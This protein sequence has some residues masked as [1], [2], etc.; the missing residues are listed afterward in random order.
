MHSV[1]RT[2]KAGSPL[3]KGIHSKSAYSNV[4]TLLLPS[5]AIT[6]H[7]HTHKAAVASLSTATRCSGASIVTIPAQR[8]LL[9]TNSKA[10]KQRFYSTSQSTSITPGSS[11]TT[12]EV[13]QELESLLAKNDYEGFQKA[14]LTA[15]ANI[16][17]DMYHFLL[18]TLAEHP[19][20]FSTLSSL[21]SSTAST[22][23]TP[24]SA[25]SHG[26]VPSDPINS[27]INILTDMSHEANMG[28][29]ALQPDRETILLLLGVA[30]SKSSLSP[31][32]LEQGGEYGAWESIRVLV[33]AIR[34]GRLPAVMSSDQWELPDLNFELD[35][36]LWKAMFECVHSSAAAITA[37]GSGLKGGLLQRELDTMTFLM[38]D[39]LIKSQDVAMD[40]QLWR[41]VVEAFGN[42]RS[43]SRLTNILPKLP[44]MD[45]ESSELYST[46]SEALANS[47]LINQAMNIMSSLSATLDALPSISPFIALARQHAKIGDYEAI[48]HDLKVWGVKGASSPMND[49]NL[50]NLHRSMLVASSTALDRLVN[51]ASRS[52]KDRQMNTLPPDV[53]PG[54]VTPPQ[55]S[56][57]QYSEAT[58]LWMRSQ[59]SMNAIP[60]GEQTPEDYDVSMRIMTRLNLL[61]PNEWRLK[62]AEKLITD[63]KQQGLKPLQ[64]TYYTLMETIARTR[65]YGVSREGGEVAERVIKVFKDMTTQEGYTAQSAKDFRPL[66]EA[67]FGIY[68]YSPFSA[69]QWVYSNQLYPASMSALKKVEGMM[70]DA[71]APEADWSSDNSNG[72]SQFHDSI[73]IASVLGG[74]GHGDKVEELLK[75]WESLPLEGIERDTLLYQTFIGASYGQEK[76]ARYVLRTARYDMLKEQPA[77]RMTPEIFAG[78]LNCCVRVQD[79]ISARALIAQYSSSGDIQKTAEWYV[80]MVRTCLMIN[81]MEEE[82]AFLLQ[83]MRKSNMRMNSFSGAFF[84]FLMDY[85]IME[86]MDYSAGREIFKDFV[87]SEQNEVK[88]LLAARD[89]YNKVSQLT[90]TA[91]SDSQ[92]ISSFKD[93]VEV[94][95]I[96]NGELNWR[97]KRLQSPVGHW[98]ERVDVTP[99][100]ASMLNLLAL[101]YIRER[102]TLLEYEKTTGFNTGSTEHLREAQI[103]MHYLT[104]EAKRHSRR[105]HVS[106]TGQ[107]EK[108]TNSS[109]IPDV[110]TETPSQS[111]SHTD[112]IPVPESRPISSSLLRDSSSRLLSFPSEF[113]SVKEERYGHASTGR[114]LYVNKYILGEYI[115]MCIKEGSPEMIAEADWALNTI[116]PRVIGKANMSKDAQRL[117]QALDSARNKQYQ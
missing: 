3:S 102:P 100:T 9:W 32:T 92:Y 99:K 103:V 91:Q 14:Y 117:R 37:Q 59:E 87:K 111:I 19:G 17:K 109:T 81:G 84:E 107:E 10:W 45:N 12:S 49:S 71:I 68:S 75:R 93:G 40:N 83:E 110:N 106:A 55:L 43:V 90:M 63:M 42:A 44:A 116:M 97:A 38:A 8:P 76:L 30:G 77:V 18:K 61:Q 22:N 41:Y 11:G 95:M 64:T 108:W 53:L 85:F 51:V 34:H 46:V 21:P 28:N 29:S 69:G 67:C 96:S 72:S 4:T 48:R 52:F 16:T 94:K 78:L 36:D 88:E 25:S 86:R 47:G 27:A 89:R 74:L 57:Q 101:S 56:R 6:F 115:D 39:Q 23:A 31:K 79:A 13:I 98:I 65:E 20:A 5:K 104:G 26:T 24:E 62:H 7:Q 15:S 112:S 66:V 1:V 58:Y 2:V 50:V 60:L 82:G 35:K 105:A 54:M 113:G 114:L 73:T 33:D 70:R 80:P